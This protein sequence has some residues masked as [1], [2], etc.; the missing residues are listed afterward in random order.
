M[1]KYTIIAPIGE[2]SFAKVYRGREK[3]TGRVR[4]HQFLSV[5]PTRNS[6]LGCSVEVHF[7][8]RQKR[9]G[10]E[11]SAARNQHPAQNET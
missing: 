1:D 9:E 3:Y 5:E 10:V 7:Q 4:I 6:A 2:G 11:L 8:I